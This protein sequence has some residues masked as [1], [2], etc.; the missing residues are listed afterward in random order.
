[1]GCI[2][3]ACP[4]GW[5]RVQGGRARGEWLGLMHRWA[6][7]QVGLV[8]STPGAGGLPSLVLPRK[9]QWL[10]FAL[11]HLSLGQNQANP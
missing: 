2:V 7:R 10:L 4:T 8:A 9:D 11:P 3:G 6:G 1:M 5:G